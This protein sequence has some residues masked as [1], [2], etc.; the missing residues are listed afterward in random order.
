MT[1]EQ[2]AGQVRTILAALGGFFVG[3]GYIDEATSIALA[4]AV[5]TIV[6]AGW[7]W[8]AKRNA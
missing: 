1:A 5:A 4:G 3:K 6:A 8:W 7:S 2:V